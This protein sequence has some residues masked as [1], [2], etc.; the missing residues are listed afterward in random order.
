MA[1]FTLYLQS[2]E[3]WGSEEFVQYFRGE[4]F[5]SSKVTYF[6][7]GENAHW[8][9]FQLS[10]LWQ[11]FPA[12]EPLIIEIKWHQMFRKITRVKILYLQE[13]VQ[14]EKEIF[15]CQ[16]TPMA[17]KWSWSGIK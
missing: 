4:I 6:G 17:A 10:G 8:L 9:S 15:T 12:S 2:E 16:N 13:G 1:K 3:H 11:V 14:K 7:Q 5:H